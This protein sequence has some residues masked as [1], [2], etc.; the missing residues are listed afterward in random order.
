M[1]ELAILIREFTAS[2]HEERT[3][4]HTGVQRLGEQNTNLGREGGGDREEERKREVMVGL[5][6]SILPITFISSLSRS[7]SSSCGSRQSTIALW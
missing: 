5:G 2:L 1:G 4:L 3:R 7:S 6:C